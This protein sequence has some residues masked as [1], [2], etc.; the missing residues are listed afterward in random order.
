M[1]T[2]RAPIT[3]TLTLTPEQA[4]RLWELVRDEAEASRDST[5]ETDDEAEKAEL[6]ADAALLFDILAAMTAAAA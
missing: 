1:H 4:D 3:L 2:E 5:N 6:R